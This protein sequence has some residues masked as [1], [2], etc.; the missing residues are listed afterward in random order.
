MVRLGRHL[1]HDIQHVWFEVLGTV[2]AHTQ[3]QL[4]RGVAGL[5]GLADTQN[6]VRGGL[7]DLGPKR[8]QIPIGICV[9][10]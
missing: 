7:G 2:G 9:Y 3:V 4:V 1:L 10:C 8:E 5:E 6:R